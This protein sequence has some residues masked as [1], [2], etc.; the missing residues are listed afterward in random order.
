MK[1]IVLLLA[2]VMSCQLLI[3]QRQSY[4]GYLEAGDEAAMM[5]DHYSAYRFYR[6]AMEFPNKENDPVALAKLGESAYHAR[7]YRVSAEALLKLLTLPEAGEY[8]NARYYLAEDY[9]FTGNYDLAALNYQTFLDEQTGADEELRERA[10]LNVDNANTSIDEAPDA[11][12]IDMNH[13]GAPINSENSD[14]AYLERTNGDRYLSSLRFVFDKDTLNP[15]RY[16]SKIMRGSGSEDPKAL[17]GVMNRERQ[18]VTH[19]TFSADGKE[20]FFTICD[21]TVRDKMI[22]NLH[23]ADAAADGTFSNV[24][25][26][27]ALNEAGFSTTM[28]NV[29]TLA[30]GTEALFFASNRPGGVGGMDLYMAPLNS[31]GEPGTIKPL[32]D[33][34]TSRND[35]TPFYHS[36]R[37]SLYFAT[38]GRFTFGGLDIYK[39]YLEGDEFTTPLNLGLPVNSSFDDAYYSQSPND[40]DKAFLSS[41]RQVPDAIFYSE[42]KE[43]CCYDIYS[44]TP[45]NRIDLLART[46]NL[47]TDQELL[48]A[49]VGL[50]LMTPNGPELVDEIINLEG[51]DFAFKLEPGQKYELRATKPGFSSVVDVIDLNDPELANQGLIRRDLYLA[52]AVELNV[53]TFNGNDD[54]ALNG[55]TV[56][57]YELDA[58]GNRIPVAEQINPDGNDVTFSLDAGKNY[59]IVGQR[60]GFG[61]AIEPL[62]LREY[63]PDGQSIRKDLYLGQLLEILVVDGITD[64]PLTGATVDLS[65]VGGDR[66]GIKTNNDGNDFNFTVNLN[67][68]F[69][70]KTSRPDYISRTDT[71]LIDPEELRLKDGR[72]RYVIPLF[73]NN[74][75]L[76]LPLE[77]YFDND[78]PNPRTYQR[79]TSLSYTETYEPYYSRRKEFIDTYTEGKPP[80]EAFPL[81]ARFM[82][83][84]DLQVKGGRDKLEAFTQ[85]LEQHL[86]NGGS[87]EIELRGFASPRAGED[88]NLRLSDRRNDAVRNYFRRYNNGALM[89]YINSGKLNMSGESF[90]ESRPTVENISDR[91]DEPRESVFGLLASQQR[92][93]QIVN[94]ANQ[95]R[96][97]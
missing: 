49:T 20:V 37:Q 34:N 50:Y 93:V 6:I 56:N 44:F 84:F 82:D 80:A 22:C 3:G 26:I 33:L 47:L 63:V 51:N 83:F 45:D 12:D 2:L 60:D 8:P 85:A 73:P 69:V 72:L 62:D 55:V 79:T 5:E 40:D 74:L 89:S 57:L 88:Y 96:K 23:R 1:K 4:S 95:K 61:E 87:F 17:E 68:S 42:D 52:P 54:S 58:E 36:E 24:R 94:A 13:L 10:Q 66:V 27:D 86:R 28:P 41:T 38:D 16:L 30:D 48:G 65:R 75:D 71:L 64:D 18:L 59:V 81:A 43:V 7:A 21:Y 29:A 46:F 77:V 78:N 67:R 19:T 32:T 91:L 97:K 9:F 15:P 53:F 70:V 31:D 11:R 92:R 76:L 35:V 25:P 39:S 90:G 14:Y